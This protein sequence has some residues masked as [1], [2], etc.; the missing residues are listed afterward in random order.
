MSKAAAKSDKEK[1]LDSTVKQK[2]ELLKLYPFDNPD[3]KILKLSKGNDANNVEFGIHFKRN[4]ALPLPSVSKIIQKTMP[5]Q[6]RMWLERWEKAQIAKLG[7][8]GFKAMKK[9]MFAHG[10]EL[11]GAVEDYFRGGSLPNIETKKD[12]TVKNLITSVSPI[13]KDFQRPALSAE[14]QVIHPTLN[15]VGYF[16]ALTYHAKSESIVLIDWKTTEKTKT[17]LKSTFDAPLQVAAY[18]GALNHD[19]RY[20]YQVENALVV[21][22]NK[23]G[24]PAKVF[25]MG[26]NLLRNYWLHWINRCLQYQTMS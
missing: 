2:R 15:Y 26:K 14:S 13:I 25:K 6:Q 19:A 22:V 5:E 9:Q 11:H 12:E 1:D 16:D 3:K 23:N 20:P 10:N 4:Y 18:V 17:T 8:E 7:I 21:V 24:N